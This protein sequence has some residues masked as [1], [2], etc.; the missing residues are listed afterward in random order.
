MKPKAKGQLLCSGSQ[1]E[2]LSDD[3]GDLSTKNLDG[4]HHFLVGDG[5]HAHLERDAGNSAQSFVYI[6]NFLGDGVGIAVYDAGRDRHSRRRNEGSL[7]A[8]GA[9]PRESV[10]ARAA[11]ARRGGP[12]AL[13]TDFGEGVGVA[14][15]EIVSGL[16]GVVPQ[17]TD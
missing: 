6:E 17:K 12:A 10:A 4:A 15:E 9:C 16:L 3:W 13:L 1:T 7:P 14:G 5:R 8:S 2:S 11:Q